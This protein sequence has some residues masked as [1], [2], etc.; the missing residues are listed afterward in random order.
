M[1]T[2]GL[3]ITILLMDL[4]ACTTSSP[5]QAV[6]SSSSITTPGLSTPSPAPEIEETIL[7]PQQ[8]NIAKGSTVT[9]DVPIAQPPLISPKT[10]DCVLTLAINKECAGFNL[11]DDD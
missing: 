3:I 1:N 4:A 11:D 8:R 7:S 10:I 9:K 2:K 5:P 6:N